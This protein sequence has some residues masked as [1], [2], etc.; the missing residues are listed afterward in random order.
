MAMYVF[1]KILKAWLVYINGLIAHK[2]RNL[3]ILTVQNIF[4][5]RTFKG[6]IALPPEIDCNKTA[7]GLPPVTSA[8]FL[9][10]NKL[11]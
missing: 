10:A 2:E 8:V 4:R 3:I 6:L 11:W 1:H 9:I 7:M 5:Y